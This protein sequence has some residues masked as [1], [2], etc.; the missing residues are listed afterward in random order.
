MHTKV[1]DVFV[2]SVTGIDGVVSRMSTSV[3]FSMVKVILVTLRSLAEASGFF[4]VTLKCWVSVVVKIADEISSP[5]EA[6]S[7]S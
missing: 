5:T 6:V 4:M 2:R 1:V 3:P 7:I